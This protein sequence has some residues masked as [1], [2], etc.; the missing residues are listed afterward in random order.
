[1]T[2]WHHAESSARRFGGKADDYIKIHAWFDDTKGDLPNHLHRALRH[3]S[4]GII[5]AAVLFGEAIT[6]SVG[7]SVPVRL[8]GEQHVK[9]DCGFIPSVAD[10]LSHLSPQPWMGRVAKRSCDS[11]EVTIDLPPEEDFQVP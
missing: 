5:D 6:N 4:R 3:H 7:T 8:I 10:W 11:G 1:M 9:E 2:P